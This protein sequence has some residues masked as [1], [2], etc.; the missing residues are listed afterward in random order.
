MNDREG[1]GEEKD[2][3]NTST[4]TCV[5]TYTVQSYKHTT[6]NPSSEA[7]KR[8]RKSGGDVTYWASRELW[9]PIYMYM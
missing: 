5:Y 7:E 6:E 4:H 2:Y 8:K 1:K 9:V 3:W